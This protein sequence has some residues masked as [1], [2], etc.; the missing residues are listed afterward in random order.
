MTKLL[1]QAGQNG[2]LEL[3]VADRGALGRDALRVCATA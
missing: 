3:L 2:S 1:S